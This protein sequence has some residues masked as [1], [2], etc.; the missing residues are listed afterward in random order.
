M[1]P[2]D[3]AP[4]VSVRLDRALVDKL[5]ALVRRT[6]RSRGFYLREAIELALPTLESRYWAHEVELSEKREQ[7]AFLRIIT[8]LVDTD[9]ETV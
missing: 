1:H 5:D 2:Q 3:P 6:G 8:S 4:V 7:A 9:D